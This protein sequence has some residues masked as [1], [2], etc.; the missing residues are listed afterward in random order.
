MFTL[1]LTAPCFL[2]CCLTSALLS[3][4]S[5]TTPCCLTSTSS[6]LPTVLLSISSLVLSISSVVLSISSVVSVLSAFCCLVFSRLLSV[7]SVCCLSVCRVVCCRRVVSVCCLSQF[8]CFCVVDLFLLFPCFHISIAVFF[9]RVLLACP[10]DACFSCLSFRH[11]L[12]Y[13]T[14]HKRQRRKLK[15]ATKSHRSVNL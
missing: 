3:L 9:L 7:S 2:T 5:L 13:S 6:A 15:I 4:S 1:L 10:L 8:L 11:A 14:R 12:A